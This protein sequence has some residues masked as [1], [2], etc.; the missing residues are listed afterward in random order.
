MNKFGVLKTKIVTKLTESY[1]TG[2]MSEFKDIFNTVK[3]NRDFRDLYL[4][5]E[6]LENKT[7]PDKETAKQY[8]E[9]MIALLKPKLI[10]ANGIS[11][12]LNKKVSGVEINE[13]EI[14]NTIDQL[15]ENDSLFNI[16]KKLMA[17]NKLVEHL[18][19]KKEQVTDPDIT[20]TTVNE[21]LL[22]A[23]LVGNFNVLYNQTLTESDKL[24]LNTILTLN[25]TDLEVAFIELKENVQTTIGKLIAEDTGSDELKSRL[26]ETSKELNGMKPTK[27]NYYR[28][29]ELKN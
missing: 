2:N 6:E 13:N 3:K 18:I 16:D 21:S 24:E 8:I 29:K 5:Y 22:N 1:A 4:F 25:D 26:L 20:K 17:K 19:S 23:V 27:L 12:R 7:L 9:E 11:S 14:Y 28:L 10:S 15:L